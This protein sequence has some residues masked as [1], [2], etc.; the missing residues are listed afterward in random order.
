MSFWKKNIQAL[1][2]QQLFFKEKLEALDCEGADFDG[3]YEL[4]AKD[5]NPILVISQNGKDNIMNSRF[6]P[7]QEAVSYAAQFN[8]IKDYSVCLFLGFGNGIFA[9][10]IMKKGSN[11]V[12]YAFYE[13]C[14]E[15]FLFTLNQYDLSDILGND[16]VTVYVEGINDREL[17]AYLPDLIDWTNIPLTDIF[18]LPKYKDMYPDAY[19]KF[20]KMTRDVVARAQMGMN[21][22]VAYAR[23]RLANCIRHM[24]FAFEGTSAKAFIDVFPKELP[25]ILVSAGPSLSNNIEVLK[26][27]KNKAFILCV[28]TALR[29]LLAE[30]IEPDAVIGVDPAKWAAYQEEFVPRYANMMWITESC[31]NAQ[32]TRLLHSYR[33]VFI[34]G[35][36]EINNHLYEQFGL[37]LLQL[38]TGGSVANSAFSL[39]E[40]WGFQTIILIGQDLALTGN[41]R[42]SDVESDAEQES[43]DKGFTLIETEGYYGGVVTTREDYFTYL[44]WFEGAFSIS[45]VPN[46][47]N[48]TEGGALIQGAR[49]MTLQDALD[50]FAT[51]EYSIRE[52]IDQVP[53]AFT[54]EQKIILEQQLR[55]FPARVNY[56]IR[57]FKEGKSL[58][59]RAMTLTQRENPDPKELAE[60]HK[61]LTQIENSTKDELEFIAISNRACEK[62]RSIVRE[63]LLQNG[64]EQDTNES[65]LKSIIELYDG[66]LEAAQDMRRFANMMVEELDEEGWR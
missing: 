54:E 31:S 17:A 49:N 12:R 48:A 44:K 33:N 1:Q 55:A 7:I 21:T 10:E 38:S 11:L 4:K 23:R 32:L 61:R 46:I 41:R 29:R 62:E 57:L 58:A 8:D 66:F 5:G 65:V 2:Q 63:Q 35:E 15:A 3:V 6:R 20:V 36:D 53:R 39:L 14:K 34:D 18:M 43:L 37:P 9:R 42:Y 59:E 30:G 64:E 13:P 26:K 27:A 56:F 47:I 28:D 50:S 52:I 45:R 40:A 25:A 16:K 24:R 22:I 60:I 51:K 19:I